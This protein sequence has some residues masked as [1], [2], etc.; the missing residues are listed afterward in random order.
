MP[1]WAIVCVICKTA[2][3]SWD[4]DDRS[5]SNFFFPAKPVFPINGL[6]ARCPKCGHGDRYSVLDLRFRAT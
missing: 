1:H 2:F 4:I 3:K 6:V 5:L